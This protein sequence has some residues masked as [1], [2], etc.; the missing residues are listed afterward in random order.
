M[1]QSLTALKRHFSAQKG[2]ETED[3]TDNS[4]FHKKCKFIR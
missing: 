1:P 4:E 2:Q 3:K